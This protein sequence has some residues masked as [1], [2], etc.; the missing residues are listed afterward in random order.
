MKVVDTTQ[1]VENSILEIRGDGKAGGGLVLAMQSLASVMVMDPKIYVQEWPFFSS[2]RKGA[3]IRSF[4]RVSKKPIHVA[5]EVTNPH[6][7]VLM[8]AGAAHFVDFALGVPAGGIFILNSTHT[9]EEAAKH[10]K[11]SGQV[12]TI[13]GDQLGTKF[14]KR[15]MANISVFATLVSLIP[16]VKF[17]D[18]AHALKHILEKRRLPEKM[19]QSNLDLFKA[20]REA[21]KSG[22]FDCAGPKDHQPPMFSGYGNL[23][24]SAQ[25]GLRIS[26]SNKTANYARAGSRVSFKDPNQSCTGCSACI[27]NCPENIIF[28]QPDSKRGVL[29][30]G[31]DFG[32][33]CKACRECIESC[34]E[35][36]FVEVPY[37][38]KWEEVV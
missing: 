14:L 7:S 9:P 6:I 22:T 3:A 12:V 33:Y 16:S 30:T 18:A 11:L 38:E 35:N 17:E 34:P 29:V 1:L 31:A 32:T 4:L 37:E 2:A 20:S 25:T 24:M 8:D 15:P 21:M 27:V 10:Y 23:P 5:C 26:K 13:D 19:V 36:L 28:S